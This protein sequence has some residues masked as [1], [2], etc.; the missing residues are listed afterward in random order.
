M[1]LL[2]VLTIGGSTAWPEDGSPA[3][4]VS[5]EEILDALLAAPLAPTKAPAWRTELDLRQGVGYAKNV[6]YSPFYEQNSPFSISEAELF[7]QRQSASMHRLSVYALGSHRHY[8]D[9][10]PDDGEYNAFAQG[11]WE[12]QPNSRSSCGVDAHYQFFDQFFDASTS[13]VELNS[14]RLKQH[15]LGA[16]TFARYAVLPHLTARVA[17][18]YK[19]AFIDDS[20]DDF[21]QTEAETSIEGQPHS[22]LTLALTYHYTFDDY[23]ER[24]KR[25]G[26]G[27]LIAEEVAAIASHEFGLN[28]TWYADATRN[29]RLRWRLS[30]RQSD[31]NGG[32]YYDYDSWQSAISLRRRIG[33]W[34]ADVRGNYTD[35][36]YDQRPSDILDPASEPLHRQ[37][38]D[39]GLRV[40]R[41]L[42]RRWSL[43]ADIS[44]E[45]NDA[46]T[47]MDVY[48]HVTS[49]IGVGFNVIETETR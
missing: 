46:N 27:E 15:D 34:S 9:V 6:L 11:E 2:T 39:L 17:G 4:Q 44:W 14:T 1:A 18:G 29:W 38:W 23:D 3:S 47:P 28:G 48:N 26:S 36:Q 5:A 16:N 13:D 31:D 37:R 35:T 33:R 42:V 24:P 49:A 30:Q 43:F 40:E 12:Y 19:A 21:Q 7:I 20:T 32:G 22:A 10:E 8:V 45:D 41:T 25:T